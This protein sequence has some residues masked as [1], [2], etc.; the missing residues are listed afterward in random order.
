M[1]EQRVERSEPAVD[2][3]RP[4]IVGLDTS[5]VPSLV[6]ANVMVMTGARTEDDRS[7]SAAEQDRRMG[8]NV[9]E[10]RLGSDFENPESHVEPRPGLN[11]AIEQNFLCPPASSPFARRV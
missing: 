3:P 4:C 8:V 6:I 11:Q 10:I 1:I 9:H 2:P 7:S 5:V